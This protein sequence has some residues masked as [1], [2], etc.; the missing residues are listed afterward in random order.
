MRSGTLTAQVKEKAAG[1][2]D[3]EDFR[4]R[5]LYASEMNVEKDRIVVK[6]KLQEYMYRSTLGWFSNPY[7]TYISYVCN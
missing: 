2:I 6:I 3:L 7:I 4:A 5:K 1:R